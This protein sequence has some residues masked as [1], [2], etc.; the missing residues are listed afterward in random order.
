MLGGNKG[1]RYCEEKYKIEVKLVI[2]G[3]HLNHLKKIVESLGIK[4]DVTFVGF[5]PKEELPLFYSA[6][7]AFVFPSFHESFGMPILEAMACGCPVNTSN[8]FSMHEVAEK[9]SILVDP[10]NPEKIANVIYKV[11]SNKKTKKK[12][13]QMEN[14]KN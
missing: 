7:E 12:V 4:D 5:I 8:I 2:G 6:T 11:V 13:R 1:I 10:Y 14:R 9:A 3:K